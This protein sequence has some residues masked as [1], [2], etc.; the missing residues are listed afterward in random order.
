MG[1]GQKPGHE[2]ELL[3]ARGLYGLVFEHSS[4]GIVVVDGAGRVL[5]QNETA[6]EHHALVTQLLSEALAEGGPL[7][8]FAA[9][10]RTT[11]RARAEKRVE[12]A[13][14]K[15]RQLLLKG[16]R[17]APDRYAIVARDVSA[18]RAIEAEVA[19][20]RRVESL[21]YLTASVVHDFNNLL[22]PI[23]CL[24]GVLT[25]E[26]EGGSR[27]G[28]MAG[29]IRDTAERAAG[30]V[31]QVLSVIRRTPERSR[32]LN[33][34][35]VVAGM[36]G[37]LRR[38]L[39]DE[40]ELVLA[41]DDDAG[42]V[43]AIREELER[44]LL[45]LAVNARDAM[46]RGGRLFI[47]T[48]PMNLVG[49]GGDKEAAGFDPPLA[50][51]Y[52][53]LRVSDTGVGMTPDVRERVFEHFFTTKPHGQGNGLGL[54]TAHRF[55][56]DSGGSISVQSV[57][58]AGTTVTVCLP[59]LDE[60]RS[61]AP[62]SNP[63]DLFPRGTETVLVVEDDTAVRTVVRALLEA[64]G[65]RV[66]DAPSGKAALE[67]VSGD[68]GTIDLLLT[69]VVMPEMSGR[70][71]A[72]ALD[73]KGLASKVLFMSGHADPVI[74]DR[75]VCPNAKNLLRKAFSPAEL[76]AKVREVLGEEAAA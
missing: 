57:E 22:T 37:L 1:I 59:R 13:D 14:G 25:R 30:L 19:Q 38:V 72:E 51:S 55:A 29:E 7:G 64:Q 63:R 50:G 16:N 61:G 65:Y 6:R 41:A 8:G 10:L 17:V 71:L 68:V 9:S 11:G 33:V 24:A 3:E 39:G 40:I 75:G 62:S 2:T 73:A 12:G 46:P 5:I 21:G 69:D 31:R 4:V 45:N 32:A 26:L 43:V 48:I 28:E 44:V 23:V 53:A 66:L 76:L 15:P 27:A 47:S 20:L 67:A 70:A 52:V 56:R 54:A 74:R 36:E 35:A 58:G 42:E 60:T 34:G 18:R 49:G